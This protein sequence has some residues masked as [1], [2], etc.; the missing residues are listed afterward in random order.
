MT[1]AQPAAIREKG[2]I[3]VTTPDRDRLI[4]LLEARRIWPRRRQDLGGTGGGARLQGGISPVKPPLPTVR[5]EGRIETAG[6][7]WP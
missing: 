3:Y 4:A 1:S 2:A 6:A 5:N 7:R